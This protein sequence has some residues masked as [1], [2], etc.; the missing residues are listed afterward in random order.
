MK[1]CIDCKH[2]AKKSEYTSFGIFGSGYYHIDICTR[3]AKRSPVNGV[4][5]SENVPRCATEREDALR[6]EQYRC[7]VDG[8]YWE[9]K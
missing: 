9:K 1:L 6:L 5:I 7:K 2:H 8:I 4:V 3:L